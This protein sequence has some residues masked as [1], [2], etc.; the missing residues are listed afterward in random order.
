MRN[1]TCPKCDGNGVRSGASVMFKKGAFGANTIPLGGY[2][3][4]W[5]ALDNYICPDCGYV[6]SYITDRSALA[7]IRAKWP[8]ASKFR[9][10]VVEEG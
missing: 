4:R 6:E 5:V 3:P 2:V 9:A 8:R 7:M 1:G 10:K